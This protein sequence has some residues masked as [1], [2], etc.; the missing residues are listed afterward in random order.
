MLVSQGYTAFVNPGSTIAAGA[1]RTAL[2]AFVNA[3]GIYIGSSGG[4]H[5][6][7]PQRGDHAAQHDD[8]QR[9]QHAGLDVRRRLR[10]RPTPAGWGFDTGGWIYR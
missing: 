9:A 6:E 1:G 2:Q 8:H 3:G 4:R 5:D 7:R 10:R